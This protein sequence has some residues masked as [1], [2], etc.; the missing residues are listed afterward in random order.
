MA[1]FMNSVETINSVSKAHI[2]SP[3]TVTLGDEFQGVAKDV[4]GAVKILL[5]FEYHI[6]RLRS[7]YSLR[8][9]VHEGEIETKINRTNSHQM[10]GPGLSQARQELSELKSTRS[11]FKISLKDE[12]LNEK[13]N[14]AFIVFQGI[15]GRWTV[16]Q[17]KV[18][19][20]LLQNP[21]YKEVAKIVKKDP[22]VIWRRKKSL[23][24]E[25][26]F[27]MRRLIILLANSKMT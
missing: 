4:G 8:Y 13:L 10:L 15:V 27:S 22:T 2:L 11:R 26:Y 7:P 9:V 23:M 12:S 20:A 25:E 24:I 1:S 18:V 21:D 16:A 3:L 6:L 19:V 5:D 17:R 14:D